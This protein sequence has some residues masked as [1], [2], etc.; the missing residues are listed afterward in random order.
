MSALITAVEPGS[1]A[2]RHH[3]QPQDTLL[4]INGHDVED[5]LDYRF[6]MVDAH[7]ELTVRDGEGKVRRIRIHKDEYEDIGLGFATYLMDQKHSCRNKCIFCFIDQ[8]PPGMRETLYFKDDDARLSFLMGNYIT[9]TNL[10]E[11]EVQRII[12]M[13]ISPV[14]VSV[15]TTNPE[16]RVKMM[17]NRFAGQSLAHLWKLARAGTHINCQLVLC[18]G[19][20][21]GAELDRTLRD[22]E[23]YYPAVQ[24]IA[25]VPVGLTRYRQGLCPLRPFTRETAARVVRQIER[26]GEE[27]LRRHGVRL[28]FAS[29]EFYLQAEIP[30]PDADFYGEFQQLEN[31]VGMEALFVREFR[32][33]LAAGPTPP[34][35]PRR[36]SA[37]TGMLAYPL[38][39]K[40][41][42]EAQK[43]VAQLDCR[44]YAIH[45]DFFGPG[46]TVAGLIT[47]RDLIAQLRG[48]ELGS[49]L[50]IP[51]SMLR[52]EGDCFLDDLT[53]AD[54]ERELHVRLRV[55]ETDGGVFLDALAGESEA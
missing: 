55:V 17:G 20:N 30:I 36:I 47:G 4:T 31:G 2:A 29:D 26:F 46:V 16:L 43:A 5:V 44:V 40:L 45:N 11:R 14:N 6:F 39:A 48:R 23:A 42:G 33:A 3:I 37:A 25:A 12:D 10:S 54:V 52:Q 34:P 32:A 7:V 50:L 41:A 22:L 28:A 8:L 13:H 27:S 1:P 51:S 18:P 15:H 49:E 9:L 19:Y 35:S 24:S 53:P 21:D 38:I